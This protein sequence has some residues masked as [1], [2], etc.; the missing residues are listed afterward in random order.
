M[1]PCMDLLGLSRCWEDGRVSGRSK[2]RSRRVKDPGFTLPAG[3]G[4]IL[5][6]KGKYIYFGNSKVGVII[7]CCGHNLK[8]TSLS[9][10]RFL[11]RGSFWLAVKFCTL[12]PI[13]FG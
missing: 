2:N 1:A 8:V 7:L 13:I 10:L 4:Y 9:E 6:P 11:P 5:W 12:R 3:I